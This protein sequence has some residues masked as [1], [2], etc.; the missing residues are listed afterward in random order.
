MLS[1]GF[2]TIAASLPATATITPTGLL[3]MPYRHQIEAFLGNDNLT[4]D[5]VNGVGIQ[6][7]YVFVSLAHVA[8][9]I[10]AIIK[11][12]YHIRRKGWGLSIATISLGLI[13]FGIVPHFV[14]WLVDPD[15]NL[16]PDSSQ[17]YLKR[18]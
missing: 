15:G 12:T 14:F 10:L 3:S 7:W 11:L 18:V 17:R 5:F 8:V 2:D 16:T 6:F 9:L 13:I 4:Y 1:K